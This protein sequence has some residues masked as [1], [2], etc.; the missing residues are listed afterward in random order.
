MMAYARDQFSG[1]AFSDHFWSTVSDLYHRG[2]VLSSRHSVV[3]GALL[4]CT[5]QADGWARMF[6]SPAQPMLRINTGLG[7]VSEWGGAMIHTYGNPSID[8]NDWSVLSEYCRLGAPQMTFASTLEELAGRYLFSVEQQE[9]VR[10]TR[11][12]LVEWV[13]GV[14]KPF[15]RLYRFASSILFRLRSVSRLRSAKPK[16]DPDVELVRH[17]VYGYNII[18][19]FDRYYAIL[20]NE[21]AFVSAKVKSGGYSSCFSGYSLEDVEHAIVEAHVHE[22]NGAQSY[23]QSSRYPQPTEGSHSHRVKESLL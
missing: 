9:V 20:Q 21:G 15:P 14:L 4:D 3:G 1:R 13:A 10:F 23:P 12:K 16:G 18:R 17:G 8:L 2:Q 7:I 11:L 5:V 19:R 22:P 6:E